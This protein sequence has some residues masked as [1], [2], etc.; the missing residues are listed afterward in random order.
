MALRKEIQ[1]RIATETTGN[2]TK[3]IPQ[4][5]KWW[6]W[7]NF[8]QDDYGLSYRVSEWSRQAAQ[9]YIKEHKDRRET[10]YDI[11]DG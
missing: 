2:T 4:K 9:R 11:I 8:W 10:T 7:R 5:K 1:Y 6:R 3:Y